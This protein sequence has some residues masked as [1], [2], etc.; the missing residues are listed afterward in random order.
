VLVVYWITKDNLVNEQVP[1]TVLGG[2][3]LVCLYV[4]CYFSDV[5]AV[6]AEALMVCF[7]TEYDLEEG[8]TYK[9][10]RACPEKLT[11]LVT[12]LEDASH[13]Q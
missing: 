4:T 13:W 6:A 10:M 3:F 2:V 11:R 8:W 9:E 7:L 12:D 5:H 1:L